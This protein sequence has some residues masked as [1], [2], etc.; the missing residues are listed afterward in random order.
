MKRPYDTLKEEVMAFYEL[1]STSYVVCNGK[2]FVFFLWCTFQKFSWSSMRSPYVLS[3]VF[4]ILNNFSVDLFKECLVLWN[5]Y[6]LMAFQRSSTGWR[7]FLGLQ[8]FKDILLSLPGSFKDIRPTTILLNTEEF[9]K[10]VCGVFT[11]KIS[12][13][14]LQ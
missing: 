11:D 8:I 14:D 1:A 12:S 2:I 3:K 4:Q 10:I 6:K 9:H 5:F 13:K 7:L